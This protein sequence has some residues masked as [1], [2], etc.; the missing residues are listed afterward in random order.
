MGNNMQWL[1]RN[2]KSFNLPNVCH[3]LCFNRH[4]KCAHWKIH[5][6]RFLLISWW[7]AGFR[8]KKK[9]MFHALCVR[10]WKHCNRFCVILEFAWKC[11]V[12][13]TLDCD[14]G[15]SCRTTYYIIWWSLI[16]VGFVFNVVSI[17]FSTITNG[18]LGLFIILNCTSIK[19]EMSWF[20]SKSL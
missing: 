1:C 13:E 5:L 20:H 9:K 6:C 19:F 2:Q 4:K 8:L 12:M 11:F 3:L 15:T 17:S 10:T 16:A 14:G 18:H 7:R